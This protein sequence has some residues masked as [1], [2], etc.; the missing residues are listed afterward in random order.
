MMLLIIWCCRGV[1][2][3]ARKVQDAVANQL[4]LQALP[5]AVGGEECMMLLLTNCC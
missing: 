5:H 4:L 2:D 1:Y 3:V